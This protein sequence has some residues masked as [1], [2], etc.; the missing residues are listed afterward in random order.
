MNPYEKY[1]LRRKIVSAAIA[2]GAVTVIGTGLLLWQPWNRVNTNDD[3][4]GGKTPGLEL[5][6]IPGG[7]NQNGGNDKDSP[8]EEKTPDTTITIGGKKVDCMIYQGDGWTIPYPMNWSV[9]EGEDG[10]V[11]F[12]PPGSSVEETCVTVSVTD[13]AEYN[14]SFIGV[15]NKEFVGEI[16]GVERLFYYGADRGYSVS[17]KMMDSDFESYERTVTAMARMMNIDGTRPF[18]ALSPVASEPDWQVMD[19][20]VILFLDKDGAGIESAAKKAVN[21]RISNWN[22]QDRANFT[23]KYRL[24][25]PEWSSSYTCVGEGDYYVEVF[26]MTVDFQVASGRADQIE[27]GQ[28]QKIRSG[29]LI[30]DDLRLYIV[31]YHDGSAVTERV[32]C[33]GDA[34][35]FGAEFVAKVLK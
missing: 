23:G 15:G 11:S 10:S 22:D 34:D 7:N 30:D 35:Y 17:G 24:G 25:T 28:N 31:V 33:W 1:Y 8:S 32:S 2:V 6:E 5:Q 4:D 9:E 14:G 21:A 12:V 20:E 3:D 26:C 19:N 13:R 18:S 16:P 27:L 29:W